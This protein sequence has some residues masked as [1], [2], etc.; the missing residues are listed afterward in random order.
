MLV[1]LLSAKGLRGH[2]W[3]LWLTGS[4]PDSCV[5]F[6]VQGE[7]AAPLRSEVRSNSANPRWGDGKGAEAGERFELLV[8]DPVTQAVRLRVLNTARTLNYLTGGQLSGGGGS[9]SA[10]SAASRDKTLSV[11]F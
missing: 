2:S 11:R 8:G 6:E 1:R 7:G 10:A 4:A 3:W 5:S 9:T